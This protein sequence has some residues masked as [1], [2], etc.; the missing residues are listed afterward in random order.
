MVDGLLTATAGS[1]HW[2]VSE[3]G[4]EGECVYECNRERERPTYVQIRTPLKRMP[5]PT[6]QFGR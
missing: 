6:P 3:G 4:R 2:W 1:F 5:F